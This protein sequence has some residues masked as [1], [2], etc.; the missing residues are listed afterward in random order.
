MKHIFFFNHRER[1]HQPD[2]IYL[3]E[4]RGVFAAKPQRGQNTVPPQK[5]LHHLLLVLSGG[6]Y[7]FVANPASCLLFSAELDKC[8]TSRCT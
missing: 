4:Y 1:L 2:R 8:E 7:L 5:K 3:S 6:R